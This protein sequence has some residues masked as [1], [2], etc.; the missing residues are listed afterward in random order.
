MYNVYMLLPV[1]DQCSDCPVH[2]RTRDRSIGLNRF[3]YITESIHFILTFNKYLRIIMFVFV[4][5]T[6]ISKSEPEVINCKDLAIGQFV[7]QTPNVSNDTQV[8]T[9][10]CDITDLLHE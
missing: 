9:Y 6:L 5:I 7:C 10:S 1:S 2:G 4:L 3:L 8:H